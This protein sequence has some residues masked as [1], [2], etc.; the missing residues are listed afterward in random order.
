MTAWIRAKWHISARGS[1]YFEGAEAEFRIPIFRAQSSDMTNVS[2]QNW[3]IFHVIKTWLSWDQLSIIREWT[4]SKDSNLVFLIIQTRS[5][6]KKFMAHNLICSLGLR[7]S[8]NMII[9][10]VNTHVGRKRRTKKGRKDK[11]EEGEKN[12]K[13]TPKRIRVWILEMER[14]MQMSWQKWRWLL[15]EVGQVF[16]YEY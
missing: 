7:S 13:K 4:Q 15:L 14:V 12:R 11:I 3:I 5:N 9:Y 2:T 10:S 6:E 16:S 8:S 1:L